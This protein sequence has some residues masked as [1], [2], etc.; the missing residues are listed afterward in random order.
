VFPSAFRFLSN[1]KIGK[2]LPMPRRIEYHYG[3]AFPPPAQTVAIEAADPVP[4]IGDTVHR[5]DRDWTVL[6]KTTN[7]L[8]PQNQEPITT[9][10]LELA[11]AG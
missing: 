11:P 7:T 8:H 4:E 6:N 1:I 10:I 2:G 9:Y 3:G 5:H